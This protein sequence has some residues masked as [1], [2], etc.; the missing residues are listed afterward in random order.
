M[1]TFRRISSLKDVYQSENDRCDGI[2]LKMAV[3]LD[4]FG[5]RNA[6]DG[7]RVAGAAVRQR[8]GHALADPAPDLLLARQHQVAP[9][10]QGC[11]LDQGQLLQ[12]GL[13]LAAQTVKTALGRY[14]SFHKRVSFQYAN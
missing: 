1:A 9:V 12:F 5:E 13:L 8:P 4:Q 14:L 3:T 11:H 2:D 10:E 7:G 6:E